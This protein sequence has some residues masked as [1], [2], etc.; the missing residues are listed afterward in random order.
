MAMSANAFTVSN[1]FTKYV[2]R[3]VYPAVEPSHAS[4]SKA[5]KVVMITGASRGIGR[6]GIAWAFATAGAGAIIIT[7]RKVESLKETEAL[8]KK[9]NPAVEVLPIALETTNEDSVSSAFA[10]VKAK[11]GHIDILVNNAGIYDS[12]GI[13]LSSTDASQTATWWREFEVNVRGTML[14]TKHFLALTGT[15]NP[16]TLIY[17]SS[18]AG[19]AVIP[20]ASAYAITKLADLQLAAFASAENSNVTAIAF[21]PGIVFTDMVQGV[22]FFHQFAKDTPHLAGS[23]VNWLA[24]EQATFL[25]GRYV[26]ANWDVEEI[27]ARKEEIVEKNLLTVG[28]IGAQGQTAV[29]KG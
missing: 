12:N 27:L 22:E 19:L 18:G 11:Y 1:S 24:S 7:A 13:N 21:H 29:V 2:Y 3:D 16:A 20:G 28:L 26:S 14:V 15:T 4:V 17:L 25:K 5:N 10:A 9:V 6:D 23:A 8:I